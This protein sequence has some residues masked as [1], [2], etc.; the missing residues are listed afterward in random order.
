MGS[1]A[2]PPPFLGR[3]CGSSARRDRL[4]RAVF[5]QT[6]RRRRDRAESLSEAQQSGCNSHR[7]SARQ[8]TGGSP[9]G[10]RRSPDQHSSVASVTWVSPEC[11]CVT[12]V[13][14]GPCPLWPFA[15]PLMSV[16]C[17]EHSTRSRTRKHAHTTHRTPHSAHRTPHSARRSRMVR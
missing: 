10:H 15:Q 8:V 5:V 1:G 16:W 6:P 13:I 14:R 3:S 4:S 11:H 9:A 7:S 17:G 2:V 12:A